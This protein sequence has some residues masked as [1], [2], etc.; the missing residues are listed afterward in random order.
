MTQNLSA[1]HV[2]RLQVSVCRFDTQR[3]P[4]ASNSK[5]SLPGTEKKRRHRT[6]SNQFFMRSEGIRR[7]NYTL[8][9]HG[10]S[11][12]KFD[13][14]IRTSAKSF[15]CRLPLNFIGHQRRRESAASVKRMRFN[16]NNSDKS[17]HR[18]IKQTS[19][20]I[21][22]AVGLEFSTQPFHCVLSLVRRRVHFGGVQ[23]TSKEIKLR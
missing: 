9:A 6:K 10:C 19:P 8:Q 12:G 2:P 21:V 22:S 23:P 5:G 1:Q 18:N 17:R 13:Q 7:T 16:S 15:H 11:E 4:K 3:R 14:I 20:K